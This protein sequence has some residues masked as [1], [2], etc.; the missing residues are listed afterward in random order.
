[1]ARTVGQIVTFGVAMIA[2]GLILLA[3]AKSGRAAAKHGWIA[4]LAE[5]VVAG[6]FIWV[7]LQAVN[8]PGVVGRSFKEAKSTSNRVHLRV[9]Q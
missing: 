5:A 4:G 2:A 9:G 8:L 7:I 1:M 3:V 6:V